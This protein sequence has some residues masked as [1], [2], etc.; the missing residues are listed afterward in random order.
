MKKLIQI[1]YLN[2]ISHISFKGGSRWLIAV[3]VLTL[4][5]DRMNM[6]IV[7]GAS[8]IHLSLFPAFISVGIFMAFYNPLINLPQ[9]TRDLSFTS[10]QQIHH[11]L[12]TLIEYFIALGAFFLS[13][14][15]ISIVFSFHLPDFSDF[16]GISGLSG[17][18]A[19]VTFSVLYYLVM[20]AAML[21]LGLIRKAKLWYP[22]FA[23]ICI[24][25]TGITL[26]IVNLM[27]DDKTFTSYH[28][29]F[30]KITDI[31]NYG[32][33]IA[34]MGILAVIVSIISYLIL[35][36]LHAPKRYEMT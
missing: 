17:I 35:L 14:A 29:V 32:Y 20:A 21:P 11:A 24:V 8:N 18:A 34:G 33:L 7:D 9:L 3:L 19:N 31:P 10:R 12:I 25:L 23:G 16:P 30:G 4:I 22:I 6:E 5:S 1:G 36:K 15:V 27:P 2:S 28:Y 13:L 26:G